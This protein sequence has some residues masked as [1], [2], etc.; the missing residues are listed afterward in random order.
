MLKAAFQLRDKI[1]RI[2]VLTEKHDVCRV[3]RISLNIHLQYV[4]RF[5]R[6]NILCNAS[7]LIGISL[8]AYI[9][10]KRAKIAM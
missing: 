3:S 5:L 6:V 9:S 7:L 1:T 8:L 4:Q 10:T 2:F